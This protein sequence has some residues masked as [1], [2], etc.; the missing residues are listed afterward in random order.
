M[1]TL[2]IFI[3]LTIVVG[4]AMIILGSMIKSEKWKNIFDFVRA[5]MSIPFIIL[6]ASL[7][8]NCFG[9]SG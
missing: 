6:F 5:F 8:P 7:F 1:I 3:E 4:S 2:P 9:I